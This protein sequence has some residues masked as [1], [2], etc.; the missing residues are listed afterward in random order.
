MEQKSPDQ[1]TIGELKQYS[2]I[3]KKQGQPITQYIMIAGIQ[4]FDLKDKNT[5]ELKRKTLWSQLVITF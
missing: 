1:M 3:L 5:D 4:Y 2:E